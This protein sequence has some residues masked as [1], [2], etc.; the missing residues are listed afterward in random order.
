MPRSLYAALLLSISTAMLGCGTTASLDRLSNEWS[1]TNT[2]LEDKVVPPVGALTASMHDLVEDL[3]AQLAEAR[4]WLKVALGGAAFTLTKTG[5]RL[6]PKLLAWLRGL[7][8]GS[9]SP[10]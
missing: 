10:A 6:L 1:R 2:V 8:N 4:A 3:R 9:S 7:R 5:R